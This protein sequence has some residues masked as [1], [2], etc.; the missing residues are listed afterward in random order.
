MRPT[1]ILFLG[2][3]LC[4]GAMSARA[5]GPAQDAVDAYTGC[6]TAH[7]RDAANRDAGGKVDA[8]AVK[9]D[10]SSERQA[11]L[12][13]LPPDVESRVIGTIDANTPDAVK[14]IAEAAK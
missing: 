8:D 1:S 2:L 11:L 10:C 14:S 12:A 7:A 13:L 6:L 3:A 4:C 9:A 5:A